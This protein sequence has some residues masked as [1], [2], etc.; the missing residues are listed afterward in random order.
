MLLLWVSENFPQESVMG[1]PCPRCGAALPPDAPRGLCPGCL[2]AAGLPDTQPHVPEEGERRQYLETLLNRRLPDYKVGRLIGRGGMGEVWL[3]EQPSLGRHVAI[4]VL[5]DAVRTDPAF[6]ERF[7]REARTMA[8]LDH[9]HIVHIFDYGCID[10]LFFI[11]MEYLPSNLRQSAFCRGC[12][13]WHLPFQAFFNLC[14]AVAYAHRK[15]IIHRDLK[16]ENI[17]VSGHVVKLADFGLARLRDTP[18]AQSAGSPTGGARLTTAHQAMGTPLYMAPEQRDRPHEADHRADIY[19]LGLILHEMLTG[20]LPDGPPETRYP[21]FDAV[22][23][24]ATDPDPKRRFG[25]VDYFKATVEQIYKSKSVNG[26]FA[27]L[28]VCALLLFGLMAF[29]RGPILQ[30]F[31]G[32]EVADPRLDRLWTWPVQMLFFG[33]V[34]LWT[35]TWWSPLLEKLA[36]GAALASLVACNVYVHVLHAELWPGPNWEIYLLFAL[37]FWVLLLETVMPFLWWGLWRSGRTFEKHGRLYAACP[38]TPALVIGSCLLVGWLAP[39]AYRHWMDVPLAALLAAPRLL[40]ASRSRLWERM[41]QHLM[42]WGG[43]FE[44]QSWKRS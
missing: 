2:L 18:E 19:A 43:D 36:V 40:A 21:Q 6:A 27:D 12:D 23:R 11:V 26:L 16:P 31:L 29:W 38:L 41:P 24:R 13:P 4:K 35:R 32:P 20:K 14:D 8:Q 3:V 30:L 22:I 5:P 25:R 34:F 17:L 44:V 10:D 15:G 7:H 33:P 37:C 42:G 39:P 1:I 9:P 28:G